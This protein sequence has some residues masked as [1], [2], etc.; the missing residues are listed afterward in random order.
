MGFG[1]E[2][3]T[4]TLNRMLDA[5]PLG[6]GTMHSS[7]NISRDACDGLARHANLRLKDRWCVH[8]D[9]LAF[10]F[11]IDGK[12]ANQPNSQHVF[13]SSIRFKIKCALFVELVVDARS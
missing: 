1:G 9:D 10:R 3:K 5:N 2:V 8:D 4:R 6:D 11:W 12:L 7:V 13:F